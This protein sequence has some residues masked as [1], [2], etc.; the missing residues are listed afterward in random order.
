M[1]RKKPPRI[2]VYPYH[3]TGTI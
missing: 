3:R 1:Q 2:V